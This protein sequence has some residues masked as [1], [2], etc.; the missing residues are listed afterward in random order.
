SDSFPVTFV[1][2]LLFIAIIAIVVLVLI[3][4]Q[5]HAQYRHLQSQHLQGQSQYEQLKSQHDGMQ[6]QYVRVQTRLNDL[7][8]EQFAEWRNKELTAV[9]QQLEQAAH[10]HAMAAAERWFAENTKRI[11]DEAIRQST[12]VVT[13][14]VTEHL[15]PYIGHFPYNPKDVR[16]LGSPID[17]V[18]FNGMSEGNVQ[19][20]VFLE[21]KTGSGS[22]NT[23][24]RR[25][26]DAI[27]SK[28]VTWKEFHVPTT[29]IG[30]SGL[31]QAEQVYR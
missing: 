21:I 30:K 9:R 1:V 24:Q 13:G 17:L 27:Q 10:E 8:R 16:F 31:P 26:R 7:A 18:V 25:I 14:K 3:Y 20:I 22:L 12:S 28:R 23:P 6:S 4:R 19:E 5:L 29:D 15:T 11:R 2:L